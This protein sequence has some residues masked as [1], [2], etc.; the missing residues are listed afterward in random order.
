MTQLLLGWKMKP[1]TNRQQHRR[2]TGRCDGLHRSRYIPGRYRYG[3]DYPVGAEVSG[4][5][6]GLTRGNPPVV[7]VKGH[8]YWYEDI[9]AFTLT[10]GG[11]VCFPLC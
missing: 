1:P 10:A 4:V 11:E 6:L 8:T 7:C 9:V 2:T 5:T 3:I